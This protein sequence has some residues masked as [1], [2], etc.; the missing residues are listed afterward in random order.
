MGRFLWVWTQLPVDKTHPARRNMSRSL[1]QGIDP[2]LNFVIAKESR[3]Y[4]VSG[5]LSLT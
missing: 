1:K 3:F 4:V 5:T 2:F